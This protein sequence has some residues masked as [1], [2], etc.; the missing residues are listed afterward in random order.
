MIVYA[1]QNKMHILL[2][3]NVDLTM[4]RPTDLLYFT[5]LSKTDS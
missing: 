1:T 2:Y 5:L 4:N 3:L